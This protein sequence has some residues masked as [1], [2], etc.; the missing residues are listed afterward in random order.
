[1]GGLAGHARVGG[2]GRPVVL[3]HG[4]A[5]SS[6]YFVPLARALAARHAV[7]A[8]DLPGYGRSETPPRALDVPQLA[9]ALREWLDVARIRAATLVGNSV[10]C[11]IAVELA[12]GA[13]ERVERLV[14]VGPTMD[15]GA[16]TLLRQGGRLA[17]DVLRE[18]LALVV[19]E[20]RDYL[21]MGPLRILAT[22]RH[23]LDDPVE[24]KL[25]DVGVPAL[26]VRGERDAIVSPEWAERVAALLPLGRLVVLPGVAHAAHWG[27]ADA[28]A[29]L[30]EELE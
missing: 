23:A 28:V 7:L 30:V 1:V 17:R 19:A 21:R 24:G 9:A 4:L 10:G 6:R 5:V 15:P 14:L 11:Q 12:V 29:R 20:S 26:V 27:A 3:V 18:P 2:S 13:P 25:A 8:P 22:A 16:P